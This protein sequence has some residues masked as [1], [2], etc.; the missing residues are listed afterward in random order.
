MLTCQGQSPKVDFSPP[1]ILPWPRNG[2][3]PQSK[4][5]ETQLTWILLYYPIKCYWPSVVLSEGQGTQQ[6]NM[7]CKLINISLQYAPIYVVGGEN[8]KLFPCYSRQNVAYHFKFPHTSVDH[9]SRI[10][11]YV[12][13]GSGS[14][15]IIRINP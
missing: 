4:K 1:T 14:G 15:K 2:L 7:L 13:Y 9:R 8:I 12:V 6:D 3:T 11:K 10:R 5:E